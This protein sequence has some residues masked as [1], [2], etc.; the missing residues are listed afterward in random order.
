[1]QAPFAWEH[2]RPPAKRQQRANGQ[3][4]PVGGSTGV[5]GPRRV[6]TAS[7]LGVAAP[8]LAGGAPNV[9]R[10]A[11]ASA[12][13]AAATPFTCQPSD[14]ELE[15]P[16]TSACQRPNPTES[17]GADSSFMDDRIS[18]RQFGDTATTADWIVRDP[19]SQI[20][21][22]A[23][24]SD[25]CRHIV[26]NSGDM[27]VAGGRALAVRMYA[28]LTASQATRLFA[29][30]PEESAEVEA[31]HPGAVWTPATHHR[32]ASAAR[33]FPRDP[34][35]RG[36]LINRPGRHACPSIDVAGRRPTES[37]PQQPLPP[38]PERRL[39]TGPHTLD[40]VLPVPQ[41]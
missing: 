19:T 7:E 6:L 20:R 9:P 39:R 27:T 10:S 2:P 3:R 23:E 8:V 11:L 26:G 41:S 25:Q 28:L 17:A 5:R 38:L 31:L 16:I 34:A 21:R 12:C 18:Y 4:Q 32:Q 40:V 30:A 13:R 22:I 24:P 1:M 15:A 35:I 29:Q 36:K 37:R 14:R 33:R